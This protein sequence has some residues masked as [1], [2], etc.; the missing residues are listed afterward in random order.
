MDKVKI[1]MAVIT[2]KPGGMIS[3]TQCE[4]GKIT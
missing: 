4:L 2:G 1:N 3:T